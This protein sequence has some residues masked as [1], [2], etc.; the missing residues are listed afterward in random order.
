MLLLIMRSRCCL[1]SDKKSFWFTEI[2]KVPLSRRFFSRQTRSSQKG[3]KLSLSIQR[4]NTTVEILLRGSHPKDCSVNT[5]CFRWS[6][7]WLTLSPRFFWHQPIFFVTVRLL[8]RWVQACSDALLLWTRF[9]SL[10]FVRPTNLPIV[11]T[12]I[13]L[14]TMNKVRF[15]SSLPTIWER[16]AK[17]KNSLTK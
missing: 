14:T 11:S 17:T 5:P 1:T 16:S 12:L 4:Q 7:S 13:K 10:L 9:Q 8:L 15:Q 6:I 3:S 2:K